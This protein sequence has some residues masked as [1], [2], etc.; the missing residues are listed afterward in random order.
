V[1]ATVRLEGGAVI[2]AFWLVRGLLEIGSYQT[3]SINL[4]GPVQKFEVKVG[5]HEDGSASQSSQTKIVSTRNY[6]HFLCG[7]NDV[8]YDYV[9]QENNFSPILAKL[10]IEPGNL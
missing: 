5:R 10:A 9:P 3:S 6:N 4:M 7:K 1:R 2:P 8:L